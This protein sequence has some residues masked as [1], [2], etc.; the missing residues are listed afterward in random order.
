PAGVISRL[1]DLREQLGLDGI[2]AELNPGGL[3]PPELETRSLHLLAHEVM[4]AFKP[5]RSAKVGHRQ[6]PFRDL[7]DRLSWPTRRPLVRRPSLRASRAGPP[8][9]DF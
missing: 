5:A 1:T 2:V 3:I 8:V 6:A 9:T 7:R 4:P